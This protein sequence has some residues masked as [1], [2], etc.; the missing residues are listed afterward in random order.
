MR[1][2]AVAACAGAAAAAVITLPGLGN[3]TLWDNSETAYGE[4]AR[5]VLLF[6]NWIV[7]HIN[8]VPWYVQPPLYF[9]IAALCAKIFGIGSFALRLP[10]ALATIGCGA[11]TAA[12]VARTSGLRTGVY[13][14]IVLSTCL[15]QAVVGRLAIMD[16]LLDL[17][18]AAAIFAGFLALQEA[19]GTALLAAAAA[20]GI[21]FLAKGLVAPVIVMLVLGVFA[22]WERLRRAPMHVPQVLWWV[23]ALA[24][25]LAIA[26]PW[27]IALYE[28]Q[29]MHALSYL[30]GH[31]TIGRYTGTIQNQSG[32]VWYYL[33][34]I[35]L[36]FFPW[37]AFLP[38]AIAWCAKC[39][40]NGD[41]GAATQLLRLSCVWIVVPLLFFSFARTK[42][43][44]YIALEFPALAV[45]VAFYLDR[46]VERAGRSA[47]IS[48]AAVPVATV[49]VGIAIALFVRDNRLASGFHELADHLVYVGAAVLAGSLLTFALFS[50][51]RRAAVAPVA[52]GAA[53]TVAVVLLALLA[54]PQ[55]ER[56]KPVPRFAAIINAQRKPS[57]AVSIDGIAGGNALLF[58]TRPRVY[59]I[60]RK[61][62]DPD[63]PVVSAQSVICRHQRVWM[64]TP[65]REALRNPTFGRSREVIAQSGKA[66][67]LLYLGPKCSHG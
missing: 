19:K 48:T 10:A 38:S 17:A 65:Q 21:G 20:A 2:P 40:R 12:A 28:R 58:Y 42:L 23:G 52:L 55:A 5:E 3:G 45:L 8:G 60:A 32:P 15:M 51:R 14:G 39:L 46:A 43:P 34:V 33:P 4:V 6:H 29:G 30:I 56:F 53:M 37:I 57:D 7:L 1:I 67:L 16:A 63:E 26:L 66:A 44:N 27:P 61:D 22:A 54:L 50:V 47:L 35:V 62:E 13:A 9:W 18:V 36:G 49:L 64:I 24:V 59:V 25:F 11:V 41:S 31:Y